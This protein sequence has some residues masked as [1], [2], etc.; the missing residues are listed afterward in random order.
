[1]EYFLFISVVSLFA[2]G[3]ISNDK[4]RVSL[5]YF[6]VIIVALLAG[7]R[8]NQDEYSQFYYLIPSL[9]D[10]VLSDFTF[11]EPFFTFIVSLFQYLSLPAQSIYLFFSS[12]VHREE[13]KS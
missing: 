6:F 13:V 4:D 7:L 12:V 3:H 8:G 9:E 10:A 2:I 1:M 11:K 5:Y